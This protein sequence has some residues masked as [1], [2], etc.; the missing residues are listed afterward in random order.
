MLP[1]RCLTTRLTELDEER[2]LTTDNSIATAMTCAVKIRRQWATI[3][4]DTIY[5]RGSADLRDA[6]AVGRGRPGVNAV[7]RIPL[8]GD[9]SSRRDWVTF[10]DE[11]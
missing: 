7:A 3:L 10:L 4:D 5:L 6:E 1:A 9:V 2:T 8:C 11:E